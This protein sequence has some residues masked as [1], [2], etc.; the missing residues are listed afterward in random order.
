VTVL[1][2]A[3]APLA[4]LRRRYRWHVLVKGAKGE[5]REVVR[6]AL[7]ALAER[8]VAGLAVDVDPVSLM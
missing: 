8:E 5:A 7:A 3:P 1:G 4:K 6:E 2:P